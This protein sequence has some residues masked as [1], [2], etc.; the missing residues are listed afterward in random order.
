MPVWLQSVGIL[1]SDHLSVSKSGLHSQVTFL[2]CRGVL[3]RECY[4]TDM[5]E[6]SDGVTGNSFVPPALLHLLCC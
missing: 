5:V 6:H 1:T 3:Y 4:F 2:A